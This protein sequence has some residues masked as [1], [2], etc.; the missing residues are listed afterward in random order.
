[1]I[2][3]DIAL[4]DRGR[5]LCFVSTLH[6]FHSLEPS[7]PF[8]K[9]R[10]FRFDWLDK[11]V[12]HNM[13]TN[14]WIHS[15]HSECNELKQLSYTLKFR[16]LWNVWEFLVNLNIWPNIPLSTSSSILQWLCK[17]VAKCEMLQENEEKVIQFVNKPLVKVP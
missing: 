15:V 1:M 12:R 17:I 2:L 16:I 8:E 9:K 7:D 13:L 5:A 11:Y 4:W 6:T 14:I 3:E 10:Y